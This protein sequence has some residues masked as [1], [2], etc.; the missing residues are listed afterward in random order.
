MILHLLMTTGG[1]DPVVLGR[2]HDLEGAAAAQGR[3]APAGRDAGYTLDPD[4]TI[5]IQ[6]LVPGFF[7]L[8]PD[9]VP[10]TQPQ[11][12]RGHFSKNALT[13]AWQG[14]TDN[15]GVVASYQLLLDGTPV[16]TLRGH[17]AP[18]DRALLPRRGAD[19]LSR[20]GRRRLGHLRQAVGAGRRAADEAAERSAEDAAPLGLVALH[21]AAERRHAAEGGAEEAARVVLALGRLAALAVPPEELGA[22]ACGRADSVN[23]T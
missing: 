7:G 6:T 16:S 20:P 11:S 12:F 9:T 17:E 21:L 3:G 1:A 19:R 2:R 15:S 13:L 5:E 8:L 14:A 23:I 10:P 4:G 18:R 22:S